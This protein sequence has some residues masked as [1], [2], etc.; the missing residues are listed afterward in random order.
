MKKCQYCAEEI[1]DEAIVCRYCGRDLVGNVEE[2]ARTRTDIMVADETGE[3]GEYLPPQ[4]HEIPE[5]QETDAPAPPLDPHPHT[6]KKKKKE[7]TPAFLIAIPIGLLLA[8]LASIGTAANR[9]TLLEKYGNSAFS[10]IFTDMVCHFI[11]NAVVWT[12][13]AA[14]VIFIFRYWGRDL[15]KKKRRWWLWLILGGIWFVACSITIGVMRDGYLGDYPVFPG[16]AGV[17]IATEVKKE[18]LPTKTDV[19]NV[20][21]VTQ[22][23]LPT[24][25]SVGMQN[26]ISEP[27]FV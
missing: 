21:P 26:A 10:P 3:R 18:V 8:T 9:A 24:S 17:S 14:F 4:L 16:L 19:P 22:T 13:V 27:S 20:L 15:A 25:G 1:Q 12:L 6:N 7:R 5:S 11:A 2:I 23:P